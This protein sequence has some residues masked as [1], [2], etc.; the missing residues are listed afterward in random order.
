[1]HGAMP[2]WRG[3]LLK[4]RE[5]F[6]FCVSHL[7]R[8]PLDFLGSSCWLIQKQSL[9]TAELVFQTILNSKCIEIQF[10]ALWF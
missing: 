10:I 6:T 8:V 5:N 1:M 3:A 9:E 4:H 2:S 7:F